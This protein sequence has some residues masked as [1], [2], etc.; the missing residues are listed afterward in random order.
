MRIALDALGGDHAPGPIVAGAVQ[1]VAA[2]PELKVVLVGDQEQVAAC[3]PVG[4]MPSGAYE[5][6]SIVG[7]SVPHHDR[8]HTGSNERLMRSERDSEL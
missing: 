7:L 6:R 2:D 8:G 4:G 3:L 5:D 1:A